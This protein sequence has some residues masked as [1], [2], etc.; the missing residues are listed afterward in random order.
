MLFL[1]LC[2]CSMFVTLKMCKERQMDVRKTNCCKWSPY[3][4]ALEHLMD[5]CVPRNKVINIY[6]S[7][8]VNI[9]QHK[10]MEQV[11]SSVAAAVASKKKKKK[12]KMPF[13]N[14]DCLGVMVSTI[15][16]FWRV[17]QGWTCLWGLERAESDEVV[18]TL[19]KIWA[20]RPHFCFH[21]NA[22]IIREELFKQLCE[23]NGPVSS[24]SARRILESNT[25]RWNPRSRP[26]LYLGYFS[27]AVNSVGVSI[28][29]YK[30]HI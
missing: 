24:S 14:H 17:S 19:E 4:W 28:G 3:W 8:I 11:M 2:H 9:F 1:L 27:A 10:Q 21:I 23:D 26:A 12:K 5:M 6:N 25:I 30:Y 13:E 7:L 18:M 16:L 20:G 29:P 15:C 22:E